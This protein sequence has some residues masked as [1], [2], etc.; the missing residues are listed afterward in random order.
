MTQDTDKSQ[1]RRRNGRPRRRAFDNGTLRLL[2]LQMI[3]E[4]PRH[5]YEIMTE[6]EAR[7]AGAYRPSPGVLYPNLSALEEDGLIASEAMDG[8]RKLCRITPLGQERLKHETAALETRTGPLLHGGHRFRHGAPPDIVEAMDRLKAALRRN[9]L[10]G[11]AAPEAVR[12]A[13]AAIRAAAD[14]VEQLGAAAAD[15]PAKDTDMTEIITRHRHEIHRR[16][17]TVRAA[18]DVTPQ[19][20]RIVLEGGGLENFSSL[21]FDDHVKL[22]FETGGGKPEMRDYTPR[23]YD[24]ADGTLTI[25]FAMHEAGPATDWARQAE[26]G[27]ALHVAGPRGSAVIA[28]VFDWHL[29]IVPCILLPPLRPP[30]HAAVSALRAAASRARASSKVPTM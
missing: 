28:Q 9:F 14:R 25:D 17:L 21:G 22:F 12:A 16:D 10:D 27:S 30:P 4:Q 18:S 5:G 24:N 20:R 13:A 3:A 19:M 15:G 7:T 23:A 2:I 6:L 11:D 1:P 8:R 26:P 29:L